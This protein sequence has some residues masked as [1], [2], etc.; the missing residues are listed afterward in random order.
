ML[1]LHYGSVLLLF[2]CSFFHILPTAGM[3]GV[4]VQSIRSSGV[5]VSKEQ[6]FAWTA[7]CI[8]GRVAYTCWQYYYIGFYYDWKTG[9]IWRSIAD[10]FEILVKI[11]GIF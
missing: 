6:A 1:L 7:R 10:I 5:N 4:F 9:P 2:S 11:A 8:P 3:H